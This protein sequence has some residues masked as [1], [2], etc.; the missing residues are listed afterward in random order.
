M[1]LNLNPSGL[2][3]K[4]SWCTVPDLD[5]IAERQK[6]PSCSF[7]MEM[8]YGR[9]LGARAISALSR[10]STSLLS[11]RRNFLC[12]CAARMCFTM[13]SMCRA[14]TSSRSSYSAPSSVS[15]EPSARLAV[16]PT[17]VLAPSLMS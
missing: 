13:G 16:C 5:R 10:R 12:A 8:A 9:V 1:R 6:T 15:G 4:Y 2:H 14:Y 3:A 7:E 11:P 17:P